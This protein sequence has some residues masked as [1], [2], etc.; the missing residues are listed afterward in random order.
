MV[1]NVEVIN[2]IRF[3]LE[4]LSAK[5]GHH[6]FEHLCRHLTRATICSNILPATG[7]VSA[8]G[9]QGRDFETFKTELKLTPAINS[10]FVSLVSQKAVAFACTIQKSNIESKIRED[11][12]KLMLNSKCEAICYFCVIDL[13]VAKRHELKSWA[14]AKYSTPLEIFDGQAISELLAIR[15]LF[16][17]AQ[18]FLGVPSELYPRSQDE[19]DWYGQSIRAWQS[20]KLPDL[21]FR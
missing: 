21:T 8:G 7:P 11:I 17:I 5:N 4:Q 1:D 19:A 14:E 3:Q 10:S 2:Y 6:D 13:P 16:W 15:E 20:K 12:D 18:R 9:D